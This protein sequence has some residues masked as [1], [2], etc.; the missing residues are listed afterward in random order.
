M[1]ASPM[2][3]Q[4][5]ESKAIPTKKVLINDP[6]ELPSH[7][8]STPGGT[9]YSTT[10]GGTKIVYEKAFLMNLRNSPISKTPPSYG[11]PE[12]LMR[13][14]TNG[15]APIRRFSPPTKNHSAKIE[16]SHDEHQFQIDI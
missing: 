6:S 13:G 16:D 2:A 12:N 1:S 14:K 8:S 10:P 11:I 15:S 5:T 7:Y 3:R 4:V 9:L